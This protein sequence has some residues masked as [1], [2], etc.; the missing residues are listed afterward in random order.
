MTPVKYELDKDS[1]LL[2]VD[3]PPAFS[4]VYPTMYGM[5]PQT[6]CAESVAEYC[7]SKTGIQNIVGDDD[8]LAI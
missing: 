1:G 4:N 3:R 2:K 8:P 6:F 5:I 7:A